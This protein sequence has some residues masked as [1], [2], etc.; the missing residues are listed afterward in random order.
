MKNYVVIVTKNTANEIFATFHKVETLDTMAKA[1]LEVSV[2]NAQELPTDM[3]DEDMRDRTYPVQH[4]TPNTIYVFQFDDFSTTVEYNCAIAC[5]SAEEYLMRLLGFR[6]CDS[7]GAWVTPQDIR[8]GA[9]TWD[10]TQRLCPTCV[11]RAEQRHETRRVIT[12]GGYHT[13]HGRIS[14]L[15]QAP[16][17]SW[18][19]DNLPEITL[20]TEMEYSNGRTHHT[21]MTATEDF[22]RFA[23]PRARTNR[24]FHCEQDC[25]VSGEIITNIMTKA[26]ALNFDWSVLTNQ[27]RANGNDESIA[28]VGHHVHIGRQALG[29]TNKEQ[30]INFLKLQYILKAYENDWIKVSGRRPSEMSYCRMFDISVIESAKSSLERLSD[31]ADAV[32]A[33]PSSM[34]CSH[35]SALIMCDDN[36]TFELRIGKSTNDPEKIKHYLSLIVGV[37]ENIKNIRFE[38]IYCMSKIFKLVPTETMNYWRRQG[39]FLN[40]IAA[41]TRGISTALR[42]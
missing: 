12:L 2:N 24:M 42:A 39:C 14:T 25:T 20:G 15:C 1:M 31:D 11:A 13:S 23:N 27:L 38:K 33:L 16:G 37:V 35:G 36:K 26:Y 30:A 21:S 10:H 40:T 32:Y 6:K 28:C 22:W 18:S 3:L 4:L 29:S 8:T 5:D 41:D 17:E 9:S 34:R 7:C 19:M